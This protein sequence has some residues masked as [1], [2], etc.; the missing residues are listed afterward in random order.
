MI[1]L[2]FFNLFEISLIFCF[3]REEM[4][5]S[6]VIA[7]CGSRF[8]LAA[9][10]LRLA[11]PQTKKNVFFLVLVGGRPVDGT[12][13]EYLFGGPVIVIR[14]VSRSVGQSVSQASVGQTVRRSVG[15]SV[16]HSV[17]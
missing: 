5:S 15:H 10:G 12:R 17:G 6:R 16:G 4:A 11:P 13:N 14:Y 7:P 8:R 1:S 2:I 9:R 3:F